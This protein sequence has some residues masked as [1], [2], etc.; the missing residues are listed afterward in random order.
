MEGSQ[1][2]PVFEALR[3]A[4]IGPKGDPYLFYRGVGEKRLFWYTILTLQCVG[5]RS[6]FHPDGRSSNF[7]H[8]TILSI[9]SSYPV[10]CDL[11]MQGLMKEMKQ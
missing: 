5:S 2:R 10:A 4:N 3:P 6:V 7:R 8:H 9:Y 11:T 1:S